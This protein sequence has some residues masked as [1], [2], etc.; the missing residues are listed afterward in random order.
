MS[1]LKCWHCGEDMIWGND[2]D[3][4]DY[5]YSGKGMLVVFHVQI[6]RL[7]QKYIYVD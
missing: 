2:F 5:G 7:P 6:V 1:K 3:F 4:E